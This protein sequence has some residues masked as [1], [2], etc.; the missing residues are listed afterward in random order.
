ML[1]YNNRH[2]S[3]VSLKSVSY[4][5]HVYKSSPQACHQALSKPLLIHSSPDQNQFRL[6][7]PLA[8]LGLHFVHIVYVPYALQKQH[9][10]A[11]DG[12]PSL[13]AVDFEG[14]MGSVVRQCLFPEDSAEEE[15]EFFGLRIRERRKCKGG[16]CYGLEFVNVWQV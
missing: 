16:C 13:Q 10:S 1:I 5:V 3:V 15:V 14:L 4:S 6:L 12:D 11:L 2:L 7:S 9:F 8:V